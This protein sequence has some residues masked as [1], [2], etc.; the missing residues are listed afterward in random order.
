MK[1]KAVLIAISATAIVAII[2]LLLLKKQAD[3][4]RKISNDIIED[5]KRVDESLQRTNDSLIRFNDS[6]GSLRTDTNTI[7]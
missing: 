5:F 4:T 2:M 3:M 7:R 6:V 1:N